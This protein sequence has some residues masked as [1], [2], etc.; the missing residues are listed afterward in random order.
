M[1]K[2]PTLF[3][4]LIAVEQ[5]D[6]SDHIYAVLADTMD[7]AMEAAVVYEGGRGTP[8]YA[9]TLGTRSIERISLEAGEVRLIGVSRAGDRHRLS[10]IAGI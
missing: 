5:P 6:G 7:R 1:S 2:K 3:A 8:R 9:G 4:Y 10:G